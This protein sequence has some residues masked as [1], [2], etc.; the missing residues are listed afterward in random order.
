MKIKKFSKL[1]SVGLAFAL[2]LA[3]VNTGFVSAAENNATQRSTLVTCVARNKVSV[4]LYH[5]KRRNSFG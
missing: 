1:L 5:S 2:C 4:L 3:P